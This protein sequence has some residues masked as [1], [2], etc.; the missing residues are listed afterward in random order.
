MFLINIGELMRALNKECLLS[1]GGSYEGQWQMG[2]ELSM[3]DPYRALNQA[4]YFFQAARGMRAK[5]FLVSIRRNEPRCEFDVYLLFP[6]TQIRTSIIIAVYLVKI[7]DKSSYRFVN[8]EI[9]LK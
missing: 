2:L 8:Q 1:I 9:W 3:S 6:R 4:S 7:R 5:C